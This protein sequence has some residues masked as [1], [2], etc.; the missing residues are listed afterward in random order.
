MSTRT[1]ESRVLSFIYERRYIMSL[2]PT[3][4]HPALPTGSQ[5]LLHLYTSDRLVHLLLSRGTLI[6]GNFGFDL[7]AFWS[8]MSLGFVEIGW[9]C[10]DAWSADDFLLYCWVFGCYWRLK[11]RFKRAFCSSATEGS[12]MIRRKEA[13]QRIPAG[14]GLSYL[15]STDLF[16]L[17]Y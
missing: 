6:G 3:P 4:R 13:A 17:P 10:W 15:W 5:E 16:I 12:Y 11:A 2:K 9:E 7:W 14:Y 8:H 1:A